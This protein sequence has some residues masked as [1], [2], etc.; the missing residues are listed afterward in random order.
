MPLGESTFHGA[1]GYMTRH[2]AKEVQERI[3]SLQM[4]TSISASKPL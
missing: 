1:V 2:T 4:M 3:G